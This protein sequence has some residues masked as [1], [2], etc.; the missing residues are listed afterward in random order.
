MLKDEQPHSLLTTPGLFNKFGIG[1]GSWNWSEIRGQRMWV[2]IVTNKEITTTYWRN[3]YILFCKCR[4]T[5]SM[6]IVMH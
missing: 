3:Q 5:Y 4:T 2:I 1:A 6:H